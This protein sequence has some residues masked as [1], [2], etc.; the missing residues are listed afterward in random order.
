MLFIQNLI[1]FYFFFEQKESKTNKISPG[2]S[3]L[4]IPKGIMFSKFQLQGLEFKNRFATR[5]KDM[6]LSHSGN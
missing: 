1:I 5:I 2:C 4:E 6:H 3:V